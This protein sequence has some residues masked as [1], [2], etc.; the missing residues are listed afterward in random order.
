MMLDESHGFETLVVRPHV[1]VW[2]ERV[3]V[4][5]EHCLA[6]LAQYHVKVG[7]GPDSAPEQV[8]WERHEPRLRQEDCLG[9]AIPSGDAHAP[10]E[11]H[12]VHEPAFQP[13][14]VL[15][16]VGDRLAV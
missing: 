11:M 4:V 16:D 3:A 15:E 12:A 9:N 13:A 10:A 14:D 8:A 5:D 2:P 7:T 6:A 1:H